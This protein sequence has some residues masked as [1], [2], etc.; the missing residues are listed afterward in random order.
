M[1]TSVQ[2][3]RRRGLILQDWLIVLGAFIVVMALAW[4][5]L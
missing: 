1:L 3:H 4:V 5:C 2:I